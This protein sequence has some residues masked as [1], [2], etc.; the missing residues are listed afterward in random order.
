M[1]NGQPLAD[2]LPVAAIEQN[3]HLYGVNLEAIR[4]TRQRLGIMSYD[5]DG[6]P[7]W[8][9]LTV[10]KKSR[11]RSGEINFDAGMIAK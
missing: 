3:A 6:Q 10:P 2:G 11:R 5:K 9:L 7:W 8:K 1:A 4:K